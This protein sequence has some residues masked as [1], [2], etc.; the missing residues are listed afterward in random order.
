[1]FG[2]K[3]RNLF[4]VYR[5]QVSLSSGN[6]DMDCWDGTWWES[7]DCATDER[8]VQEVSIVIICFSIIDRTSLENAETK[9]RDEAQSKAPGA[10]IVL[11]G[12][13]SRMYKDA[14]AGPWVTKEMVQQAKVATGA[15]SYVECSAFDFNSGAA[16][17]ATA[18]QCARVVN[19]IATG[20]VPH[21]GKQMSHEQYFLFLFIYSFIYLKF[22][23]LF[24]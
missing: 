20:A 6:V 4:E 8:V 5:I 9:W 10:P 17:F 19:P 2:A 12:T 22:N 18:A 7:Y 23:Y 1:M 16:V 13:K 24:L 15:V 3:Y 14:G 11:V 21:L